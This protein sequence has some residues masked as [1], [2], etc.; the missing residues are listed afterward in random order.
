MYLCYFQALHDFEED[1]KTVKTFEML[2]EKKRTLISNINFR[3]QEDKNKNIENPL[4]LQRI[5]YDKN[6][7]N[8]CTWEK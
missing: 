5:I 7:N 3:H 4:N 1:F 6:K 2:K 8:L